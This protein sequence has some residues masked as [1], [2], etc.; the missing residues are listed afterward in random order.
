MSRF[1]MSFTSL[2]IPAEVEIHYQICSGEKRKKKLLRFFN[3][4]PERVRILLPRF[5]FILLQ[6]MPCRKV[7]SLFLALNINFL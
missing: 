1:F 6:R 2:E 3:E 5:K 4:P 7:R